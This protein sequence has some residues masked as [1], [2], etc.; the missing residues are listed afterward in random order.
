MQALGQRKGRINDQ[1][2]GSH[3]LE[4]RKRVKENR[5]HKSKSWFGETGNQ[6]K[7]EGNKN[8]N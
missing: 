1:K 6:E 2:A 4:K 8:T 3:K 5:N 7:R